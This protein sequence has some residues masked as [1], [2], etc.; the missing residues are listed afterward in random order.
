[1]VVRAST[2]EAKLAVPVAFDEVGF[3]PLNDTGTQ[4]LFRYAAAA[5]ERRS[6]GIA[7]HWPFE[8][9]GRFLPEQTTRRLHARPPAAPRHRGGPEGESCRMKEARSRQGAPRK[10]G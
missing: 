2:F 4:L 3:A 9:W 8:D 6:L 10:K 7:G 5:Y 1:M